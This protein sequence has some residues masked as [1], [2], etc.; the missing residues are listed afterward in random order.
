MMKLAKFDAAEY[1]D[2]EEVIAEYL[3][4]ALEDDNP[5]VFLTAVRD[6]AKARGITEL[7]KNAGFLNGRA[8]NNDRY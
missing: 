2:K 8:C 5:N 1:L 6:V 3:N 4:V 7:A